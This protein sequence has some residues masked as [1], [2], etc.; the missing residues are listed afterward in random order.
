M[1]II[2]S[3]QV[4]CKRS[5]GHGDTWGKNCAASTAALFVCPEGPALEGRMGLLHSV[6]DSRELLPLGAKLLR[7]TT[8][9]LLMEVFMLTEGQERRK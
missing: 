3:V 5:H 6:I 1:G 9:N 7:E 8:G 2:F 4:Q